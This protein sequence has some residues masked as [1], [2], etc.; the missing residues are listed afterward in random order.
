VLQDHLAH[1]RQSEVIPQSEDLEECCENHEKQDDREKSLVAE[2]GRHHVGEGANTGMLFS[3][4]LGLQ[5]LLPRHSPGS[6]L[7]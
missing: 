2:D 3:P 1:E 5:R 4:G 6:G 7:R